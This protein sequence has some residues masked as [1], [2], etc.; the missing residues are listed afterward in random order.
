MTKPYPPPPI[1]YP[2]PRPIEPKPP[3]KPLPDIVYPESVRFRGMEI[4]LL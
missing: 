3:E 2:K 4:E 1:P